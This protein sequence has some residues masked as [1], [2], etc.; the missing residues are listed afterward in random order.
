MTR[1]YCRRFRVRGYELDAAGRVHDSVYLH[2]VQQAAF[3]AS[4]D[5][6]YDSRRYAALGAI[7]VIRSQTIVF[8]AP[9]FYGE[10]V[11]LTT[12]VSAFSRV[13]SQR[14]SELRRMSD[15]RIVAVARVDW[16]Y[17]DSATGFPRRFPAGMIDAFQPNGRSALDSIAA[18]EP[19]VAME[20]QCFASRHCV[21]NYELDNLRHVNKIN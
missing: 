17:I 20:G 19:V 4:T 6:G 16:V 15:N 9:L 18:A 14:E 13:R 1:T 21:K 2:F 12:W 3:E 5:A 8:L 10:T 7:W 11:E